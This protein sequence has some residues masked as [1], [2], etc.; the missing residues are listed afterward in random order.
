MKYMKGLSFVAVIFALSG[1]GGP[2]IDAAVKQAVQ[3]AL[4][5]P[6]TN[7]FSAGIRSKTCSISGEMISCHL[8][9]DYKDLVGVTYRVETDTMLMQDQG[10]WHFQDERRIFRG[11]KLIN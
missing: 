4:S 7:A 3:N 11:G 8:V 9:M 5:V 10:S 6:F 1:C 2:D